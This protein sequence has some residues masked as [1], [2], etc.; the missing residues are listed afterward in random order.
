[1]RA[2][3]ST[4]GGGWADDL[5]K[6]TDSLSASEAAK[7]ASKV[8]PQHCCRVAGPGAGAYCCVLLCMQHLLQSG[9]PGSGRTFSVL[10]YMQLGSSTCSLVA[11][12]LRECL[13]LGF[14]STPR[15]AHDPLST[16]PYIPHPL[17]L[18]PVAHPRLAR[19]CLIAL[20][21]CTAPL[22]T[23]TKHVQP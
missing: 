14:T 11:L 22:G 20:L 2:A 10:L 6:A 12:L 1:M 13:F 17:T 18:F 23:V 19:L 3:S 5:K 4:L 9:W 16:A 15:N 21:V 8:R 7:G